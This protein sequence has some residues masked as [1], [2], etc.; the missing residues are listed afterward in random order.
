MKLK[1]YFKKG[2]LTENPVLFQFLGL[3]PA[4]ATST[5]LITAFVMG[6]SATVVLICSNVVISLLRKLIPEK[7]RIVAYIVIIGGFVTVVDMVL[8]AYFNSIHNAL[9]LFVPLIVVN[10]MILARAE[11]FASKNKVLPSL[12]DGLTM[13]LGFTLAISL[14]GLVREIFGSGTVLGYTVFG[15][16]APL[17]I[18]ALPAGGF[19][20]LGF[21]IALAQHF[22]KRNKGGEES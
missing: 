8:E 2:I 20:A 17:S 7:I 3:C 12:L 18:L 4:L 15:G 14:L 21:I 13:G 11:S 1:E 22:I 19:L 6:L 16:A 9:G 5:T 10:C